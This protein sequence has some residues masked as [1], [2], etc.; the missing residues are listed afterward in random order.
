MSKY[1]EITDDLIVDH[2]VNNPLGYD[3]CHDARNY[4][5]TFLKGYRDAESGK[6]ERDKEWSMAEANAYDL[7]R[8]EW[9]N[10]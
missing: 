7:G 4:P 6:M 3:S 5:Y 2:V 9:E 8:Y 1:V 10:S